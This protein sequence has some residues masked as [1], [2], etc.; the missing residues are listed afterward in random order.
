MHALS[1]TQIL[2]SRLLI[3]MYDTQNH[4]DQ[5]E[6]G[7]QTNPNFV[8]LLL[9]EKV[10]VSRVDHATIISFSSSDNIFF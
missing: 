4:T 1:T 5:T 2:V 3:I 7:E 9:H 6:D 10:K 8:S